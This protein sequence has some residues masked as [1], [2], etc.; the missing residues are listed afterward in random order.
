[1][2]VHHPLAVRDSLSIEDVRDELFIMISPEDNPESSQLIINYC[3]KHGFVPNA[4]YAS[5]ME[6]QALWVES[7][8][9]ITILDSCCSLIN[10]PKLKFYE[11]DS[12]W[13]PSL[14]VCW[15]QNNYNP[16]IPI[17]LE[18]LAELTGEEA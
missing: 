4:K 14:V 5:S 13:D 1:M 9:G 8:V 15:N 11:F 12:D 2:S 10:N 7:G 6:E 18:T 3:K 16:M 17:F